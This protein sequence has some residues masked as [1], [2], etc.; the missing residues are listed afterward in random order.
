VVSLKGRGMGWS[1][2]AH[3][4]FTAASDTASIETTILVE[5]L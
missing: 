4:P 2:D 5:A 3:L 1:R